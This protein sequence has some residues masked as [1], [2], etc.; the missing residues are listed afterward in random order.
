ME[1][2]IGT[3]PIEYKWAISI[4][5]KDNHILWVC[6]KIFFT[7][8]HRGDAPPFL[9]FTWT[10]SCKLQ[11]PCNPKGWQLEGPTLWGWLP[12]KVEG[13]CLH[14]HCW[15]TDLT[16]PR[17]ALHLHLELHKRIHFL[18]LSHLWIGVLLFTAKNILNKYVYTYIYHV[19]IYTHTSLNLSMLLQNLS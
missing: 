6:K 9:Q 12:K 15:A 18:L 11:L 10:L 13:I 17:A 8:T 14:W 19:Y 1:I 16:V 3:T 5:I 4:K 2:W 7:H